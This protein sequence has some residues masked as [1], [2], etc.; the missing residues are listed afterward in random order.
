LVLTQIRMILYQST[1]TEIIQHWTPNLDDFIKI[2]KTQVG[3]DE[4]M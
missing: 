2:V 3:V 1:T 4:A